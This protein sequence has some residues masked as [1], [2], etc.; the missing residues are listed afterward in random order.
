MSAG[1]AH[2]DKLQSLGVMVQFDDMGGELLAANPRHALQAL[3][4]LLG[5]AASVQIFLPLWIKVKATSKR[6]SAKRSSMRTMCWYSVF[7]VRKNLRL[8]RHVEEEV[9]D[10][11]A[12]S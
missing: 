3:Q 9:A 12:G 4:L 5:A 1:P 10:L 8:R 2:P 6:D 7:S 11:D